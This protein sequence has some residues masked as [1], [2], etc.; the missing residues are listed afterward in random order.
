MIET[1]RRAHDHKGAAFVE[2]YQNCNVFNDGAFDGVLANKDT[3]SQMLIPLRHGEPIRFG[4]DGERG[5][6]IDKQGRASI[7][8]VADVG[9]DQIVVHDESRDD[10]M[11]AFT[12]SRV[13]TGPTMPTPIGVFR[14]V[15][16]AEYGQGVNQQL[17]AAQSD[18]GPGDLAALLSSGA[19]WTVT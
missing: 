2:I 9:E 17:A 5:V 13:A 3:R 10:P 18:K 19:T 15:E 1:F 16:R 14:A 8:E 11:L 6:T 12:L 7:V 4:P